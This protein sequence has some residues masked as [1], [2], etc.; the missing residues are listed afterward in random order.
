M[1]EGI[2]D[3]VRVVDMAAGIGGSVAALLLAEAGADVVKVEG[4]WAE[5]P[6]IG[7]ENGIRTWDRSKRRV[8]IDITTEGGREE[9]ERL[10]AQ[11]DVL[12]HELS[13]L[14]ARA[15][16]LDD[17]ALARRHPRLIVSSVL[18]WPANH[19]DAE[20]PVDELL[21]MARLGI[22]DEQKAMTRDGPVMIRFPLGAWGAAYLAAIGV[23]ARLL[24]RLGTGSGGQ[25]HTSL[26]QGALVPMGMHWCRAQNS[27]PALATGMPKE[28]G[29]SQASLFE[30]SDGVWIHLMTCPDHAPLMS[31]ALHTMGEEG[32]R[33][34]NAAVAGN[35]FAYPNRGANVVA[36][37][38]RPSSEWLADFWAN[39][40]A[41]QPALPFGAILHD[42]Q[43][44]LDGYVVELEDPQVGTIAVPGVSMTTEPPTRI[45][46]PRPSSTV[47]PFDVVLDWEA[48]AQRPDPD[49]PRGAAGAPK[50]PLEGLKVLDL[51]NYLAG[52]YG[53]ML[54]ADLGADVIKVESTAGDAM[55]HVPWAFAGCQRGKRSVALD[56][57]DAQTRS[58]V[59]ALLRWADVVHH[60]LRRPAARRL[61]LDYDSVSRVNPDVVYCHTSSYGP[62]GPRADWPGYDQLFQAACGWEALGAGEGNPPMWHR[63]GFMDHQCAMASV[64]ATLLGLYRRRLTGKGSSV[65]A[66]LLGAGV[67]TV[68][69]TY[70]GSDGVLAPVPGLDAHQTHIEPGYGIIEVL[71]GWIAVACRSDEH[72]RALCAVGGVASL[73]EVPAALALRHR[74]AV[75]A[76]LASAGIPAEEVARAQRD[77]FFDSPANAVAGLVASYLSAEYGHIEQ[78]GALWSF[79]DLNVRLELAPPALGQHTVEALTSVGV[80][81]EELGRLIAKGAAR[82]G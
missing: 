26:V 32:V 77:A 71:D 31:A 3:D 68:S 40:V 21:A 61:G 49:L 48:H 50:W 52:P 10:L 27:S 15:V 6:P 53:P 12:I 44:V 72:R 62:T 11:A 5:P 66:S 63:F 70:V 55:R 35:A 80:E 74:A 78:P 19:P 30:C 20:R 25:A 79:G 69:E 81:H 46:F 34:A 24:V 58:A 56:L 29:G 57:K 1:G 43:T 37:R 16:A 82:Q 73:D 22:C 13:P 76:D 60:N 28:S 65:A 39:D 67:L 51:G 17:P 64:V 33:Q 8:L 18:S 7:A 14:R 23:M 75:L 54:L 45:R 38:T 9:L 42:E 36:F 2:L 59:E 41:A 4:P 47:A